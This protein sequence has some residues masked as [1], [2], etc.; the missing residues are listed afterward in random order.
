MTENTNL[1]DFRE[2]LDELKYIF[3]DGQE[4]IKYDLTRAIESLSLY[5]HSNAALISGQQEIVDRQQHVISVGAGNA[6][7]GASLSEGML[8]IEEYSS[9]LAGIGLQFIE[10]LRGQLRIP[11]VWFR[12]SLRNLTPIYRRIL[13]IALENPL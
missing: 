12:L 10:F 1:S 9:N 5:L 3:L 8:L 11:L 2:I 6:S 7:S 4:S 13:L